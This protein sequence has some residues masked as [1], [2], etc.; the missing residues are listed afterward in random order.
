MMGDTTTVGG[1]IGGESGLY[2]LFWVEGNPKQVRSVTFNCFN[3]AHL[4]FSQKPTVSR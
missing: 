1:A 3:K 4:A 2:T